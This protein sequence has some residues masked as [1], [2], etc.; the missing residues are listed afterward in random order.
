MT[1]VDSVDHF[2]HIDDVE[3][4]DDFDRID[5]VGDIDSHLGTTTLRCNPKA[6]E[7]QTPLPRYPGPAADKTV[8]AE[9]LTRY[10][11]DKLLHDVNHQG[12]ASWALRPLAA[13]CGWLGIHGVGQTNCVSCATAVADTLKQGVAYRAI[14][15]LKGAKISEFE[16]AQHTEGKLYPSAHALLQQLVSDPK[17]ING[18]LTIVRPKSWWRKIVSPVDGHAC[19]LIKIGSALHLVDSQKRIHITVDI[20]MKNKTNAMFS[21]INPTTGHQTTH[22]GEPTM[23]GSQVQFEPEWLHSLAHF[24]GP[25][26]AS[27]QALELRDIGF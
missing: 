23:S 17:D 12:R 9:H 25:V 13:V 8:Y 18:I 4:V 1:H 11:E 15:N 19:N 3:C 22:A 21:A 5:D 24:I 26:A 2:K 27:D 20:P 7:P 14:P 10:I 6:P 16:H